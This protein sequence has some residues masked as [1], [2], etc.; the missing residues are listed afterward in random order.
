MNVIINGFHEWELI[1]FV[2]RYLEKYD[3]KYCEYIGALTD[4]APIIPAGTSLKI[5]HFRDIAKGKYPIE[6]KFLLP[7]DK[8]L[9]EDMA[10]CETVVLRMIDRL[11]P[12]LGKLDYNQR[13]Q[14]Y[15]KH[16][17][18]WNHVIVSSK[19]EF[20]LS[21]NIPH[22]VYDYVIYSLCKYYN[23]AT[24]LF[25]QSLPDF[26]FLIDNMSF[27][28]RELEELYAE[29]INENTTVN[30]SL[31]AKRI[32]DSYTDKTNDPTPFYMIEKRTMSALLKKILPFIKMGIRSNIKYQF[33]RMKYNIT[34]NK[35]ATSPDLKKKYIYLPLHYQPEL[36]TS[37]LAGPFVEQSLVISM[38]S[39]CIPDDVLI[40]V[41]EHPKQGIYGRT[42]EFYEEISKIQKV[43]LINK[44]FDTFRLIKNSIAVATCTGTAGWEALFREKPVLLFGDF[45][46]QYCKGVFKI[47][48]TDDC[49]NAIRDILNNVKPNI[50]S[51][52][53][54]LFCVDKISAE[55]F[56]D[57]AYKQVSKVKAQDNIDNLFDAF[58]RK[59]R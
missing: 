32:Y 59:Y 46:Y 21:S 12:Y 1:D 34:Y 10:C 45:F 3:V 48:S 36:T 19:I 50:D 56:I 49:R 15:L 55:G 37:P 29:K 57:Y 13:K 35:Y 38:L 30:L 54:F 17:R 58:A 53:K 27:N 7:L 43:V 8:K 26:V 20:F 11:E 39:Y 5:L 24:I 23:I 51:V 18:Y 31:R 16:L 14:L 6:D 41:K 4:K 52:K 44:G 33:G 22:E 47:K 28:M 42:I 40:Y 25:H 2:S 9:L